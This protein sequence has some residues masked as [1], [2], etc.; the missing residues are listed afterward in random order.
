[1]NLLRKF[2]FPQNDCNSSM[3]LGWVM[4]KMASFLAGSIII[5]SLDMICPK[6]F[7]SSRPKSVFLGFKEIPNFLH[8]I[9]TLLRWSKCSLLD[10]EKIVMSSCYTTKKSWI[11]LKKAISIA[12]LNATPAF[13]NPKGIFK[14]MK[15]PQG[16]VNTVLA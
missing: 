10:L 15:V 13:I 11:S 1:M 7:P 14:Y 16:V 9:N 6:N 3:F 5:P 12:L 2:I 4:V 8:L